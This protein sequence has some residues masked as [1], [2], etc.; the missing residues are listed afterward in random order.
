MP[1]LAPGACLIEAYVAHL[2]AAFAAGHTATA[3]GLRRSLDR[4]SAPAAESRALLEALQLLGALRSET[5][6]V[7]DECERAG[8]AAVAR[9]CRGVVDNPLCAFTPVQRW[10]V[11]ALTGRTVNRMLLV[12]GAPDDED[13]L[14]D[15]KFLLFLL[16]LW[17]LAHLE[18][19]ETAR[20]ELSDDAALAPA[21]A[22]A[23]G[24]QGGGPRALPR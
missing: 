13:T 17:S 5:A 9:V 7:L 11:C 2:L 16:G 3:D 24:E 10:G 4:V 19:V 22:A 14:V 12:A 21:A 23:A 18:L 6:R 15:D 20:A 8:C 1:A